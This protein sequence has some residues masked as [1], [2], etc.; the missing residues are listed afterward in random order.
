MRLYKLQ[1]EPMKTIIKS[2]SLYP[3]HSQISR[4]EQ[5]VLHLIAHEK[6]SKEIA[7]DLYISS[8]T[9]IS[10]RKNLMEKLDVKNAAGLVRRGFELGLLSIHAY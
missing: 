5:E 10:H 8:H 3:L 7:A 4:R 1:N 2:K 6:T 9:A